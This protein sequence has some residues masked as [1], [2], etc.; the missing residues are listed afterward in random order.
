MT[1]INEITRLLY[2]I[3]ADNKQKEDL[4]IAFQSAKNQLHK[5][6]QISD[7]QVLFIIM[8]LISFMN[9]GEFIIYDFENFFLNKMN[10]QK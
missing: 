10:V 5:K 3:Y 8:S 4:I 6:T 1:K 2:S 7:L 9:D